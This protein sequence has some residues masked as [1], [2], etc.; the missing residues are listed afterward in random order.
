M[1]IRDYGRYSAVAKWHER[2]GR[3]V[4]PEISKQ[5][6][7]LDNLF[8]ATFNPQQLQMLA[9]MIAQSTLQAHGEV[10]QVERG[11]E[12]LQRVTAQREKEEFDNAVSRRITDHATIPGGLST[13]EWQRVKD[14]K[15]IKRGGQQVQINQRI[16]DAATREATKHLD[17]KGRGFTAKEWTDKLDKLENA[18]RGTTWGATV[19]QLGLKDSPE[20]ENAADRHKMESIADH[21]APKN[22]VKELHPTER[23]SAKALIAESYMKDRISS[24]RSERDAQELVRP[25]LYNAA[26]RIAE[27]EGEHRR[28]DVAKAILEHWED[29]EPQPEH[30]YED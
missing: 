5:L 18:I 13:K 16:L 26:A 4:P 20:L 24:I 25:E 28:G 14:G 3:S 8:M 23:D 7:A 19:R 11:H 21:F 15:P 12:A 9:P 29:D 27:E 22:T 17:V 10:V 30:E 2:N 1:A 6:E